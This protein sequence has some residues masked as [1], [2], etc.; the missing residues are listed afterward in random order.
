M[1]G[2]VYEVEEIAQIIVDGHNNKH[3]VL[4]K[5][6]L[7]FDETEKI[8]EHIIKTMNDRNTRVFQTIDRKDIY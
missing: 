3:K 5:K 4:F 6:H 2:K 1:R 7:G 8:K